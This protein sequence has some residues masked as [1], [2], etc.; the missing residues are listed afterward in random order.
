MGEVRKDIRVN[1]DFSEEQKQLREEA[2][3]MLAKECTAAEVREVLDDPDTAFDPGLWSKIAGQGWLAASIPEEF[4]GL[5]LGH[6]ELCCIAE[7]LGRAVAPV[8][9]ASTAYVLAEALM[10]AGSEAQ[11]RRLLPRIASGEAIGALATS[12][13]PGPVCDRTI[14]ARVANG[15][16]TGT[17]VPV[18]DGS[19]ATVVVILARDEDGLGLFLAE[20]DDATIRRDAV[21]TLDPSRDAARIEFAD[22]PVERLGPAGSG[23]DL[24]SRVLDRTA[25]LLAFEQVG[26]AEAAMEMARDYALARYAF[27]RPIA[28]YQAMKHKL[29]DVFI[30][31]ALARSNAYHGAWALQT[32]AA[33]LPLVAAKARVSACEAYWFAAKENIHIHG[34]MGFTWEFDCH[35]YYRRS[36]FLTLELGGLSVWE[37][38]LVDGLQAA[39]A[40]A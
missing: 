24:L 15:L 16:L 18:T 2:R 10:L 34:G 4:G 25:V 35:L 39:A 20:M 37:D 9:F 31:S 19:I 1:F 6:L 28:S 3:K 12:E 23:L 5:G 29:A 32:G 30:K 21:R 11:K 13:R 8:P 40:Q 14:A 38:R 26:G 7:E 22:T 36:N 27:G 33:E 17:K